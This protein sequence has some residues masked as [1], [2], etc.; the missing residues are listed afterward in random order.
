M[1]AAKFECVLFA[2]ILF[3]V[4]L[5][6]LLFTTSC[7]CG[8]S[9]YDYSITDQAFQVWTI[10]AYECHPASS[11]DGNGLYDLV[12]TVPGE[13]NSCVSFSYLDIRSHERIEPTGYHIP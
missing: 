5:F 3:I 4:A 6:V 13:N 2:T 10:S 11:L 1:P 7:G 8:G 9:L 12:C